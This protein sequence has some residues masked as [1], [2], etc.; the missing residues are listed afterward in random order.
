M[1]ILILL[2]GFKECK[3]L[4]RKP[5]ILFEEYDAVNEYL[6]NLIENND[7][8]GDGNRIY[9]RIECYDEDLIK[10][11]NMNT[12]VHPAKIKKILFKIWN[13]EV[14]INGEYDELEGIAHDDS[15][16]DT[17]RYRTRKTKKYCI[18]FF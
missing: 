7:D 3:S 5:K 4:K 17:K 8:T 18:H 16:D 6:N 12:S 10:D 15:D 14:D 13:T 1:L 2:I 9:A 11:I